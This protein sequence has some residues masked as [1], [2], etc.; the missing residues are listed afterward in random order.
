MP[1]PGN[2]YRLVGYRHII[3]QRVKRFSRLGSRERSHIRALSYGIPYA[4]PRFLSK[5]LGARPARSFGFAGTSE[6][7]RRGSLAYVSTLLL[8]AIILAQVDVFGSS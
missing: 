5:S 1:F 3:Q 6:L 7:E 4:S 2:L 8:D